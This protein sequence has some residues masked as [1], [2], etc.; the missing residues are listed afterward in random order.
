MKPE[1]RNQKPEGK[2]SRAFQALSLYFPSSF[3][4]LLSLFPLFLLPACG[5]DK[6][7][8]P[9]NTTTSQPVLIAAQPNSGKA[10]DTITLLGV[11]FSVV[12]NENI[13]LVGNV[14]AQALSH[15]FINGPN[16]AS[17]EITFQL[18]ST[19]SL[20]AGTIEVLVGETV[21]NGLPFTVESP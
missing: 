7:P 14:T 21:S 10:G 4:R 18:P 12:I 6:G 2:R 20:G 9:S 15:Q 16:G 13:V 11:G 17:E 8:G 3:F 1:T 5:S 19:A